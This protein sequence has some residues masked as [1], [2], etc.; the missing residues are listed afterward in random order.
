MYVRRVDLRDFRNYGRLGLDLAG[1]IT[2]LCGPN[3]AGKSNLLEGLC[4]AASAESPR[5]RATEEIVR[6]G[7]EHGFV[8]TRVVRG[9]EELRLEVGLARNGRRQIK[10]N[11]VERRRADLIGLAPVVYFS[12]DD[13]EVVKGEP[14]RRRRVLDTALCGLSRGYYFHLLRYRRAIEQR[15]RLL[16]ELRSGR[17]KSGSLSPWDRAAA[18]YGA[19]VMVDRRA[20]VGRL[21]SESGAA[22]ARLVGEKGSFVMKYRPSVDLASGQKEAAAEEE[23]TRLVE[24]VAT[25]LEEG[26][27]RERAGDVERGATRLGPHRD[28]LELLLGGQPVRT[29]GSQ[30]EQRSCGVAI[31]LGLAR[32][33]EEMTGERPL[34]ALDDVLSELDA[35]ARAGV[36][37]ACDGAEQVLI[38]CCDAREI[39]EPARAG[40]TVFEVEDGRVG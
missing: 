23:R 1:G 40:A 3:G 29:F 20:F 15:N 10:V 28:D 31:R 32:V 13:I 17:G 16:R 22:H 30:G 33:A 24:E 8:G 14:A 18:R 9:G 21:S 19:R 38:T 37:A 35:R 11:G 25:A 36:F 2:V 4:V 39:P 6:L 27:R 7:C 34:L 12:A 26:L 5:T